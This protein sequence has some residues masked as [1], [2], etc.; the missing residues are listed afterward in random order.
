MKARLLTASI[1]LS[2]CALLAADRG[3][4]GAHQPGVG[5]RRLHVAQEHREAAGRAQGADRRA[6]R[7]DRRREPA[8]EK[9]RAPPAVRER[10]LALLNGRPWTPEVEYRQSLVLRTDRVV[11][12]SSKPYT[13]R[14]EQI[15]APSLDLQRT[16]SAHV[17]LTRRP[18]PPRPGERPEPPATVKDFGTLRRRRARSARVAVRVRA[19]SARRGRRRVHAG[20]RPGRPGEAARRRGAAGRAA[21]G[22]RRRWSRASRRTPRRRPRRCARRSCSPSIG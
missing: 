12:D 11:V 3:G 17:M 15:F 16:V 10:D 14:I 4:A 22:R 18:T 5:A 21:Q 6:R 2:L 20:G 13:A 8:R 1:C 9:R 19:R 7:A